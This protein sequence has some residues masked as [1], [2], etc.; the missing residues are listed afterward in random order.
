MYLL[1]LLLMIQIMPL[2]GM[3]QTID[4]E[5][6]TEQRLLLNIQHNGYTVKDICKMIVTNPATS[7]L[8]ALLTQTAGFSLPYQQNPCYLD[9]ESWFF[10]KVPIFILTLVAFLKAY[11]KYV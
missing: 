10:F 3:E 11:A 7:L 2:Y 5:Q 4:N 8:G 9:T 1:V 6:E